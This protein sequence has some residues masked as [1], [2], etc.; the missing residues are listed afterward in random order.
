MSAK[1]RFDLIIS[2][3]GVNL[4]WA[5]YMWTLAPRGRL[6]LVGVSSAPLNVTP[7]AL[8]AGQRSVS[9][10]LVGSPATMAKM[11]D[12]AARHDITP[13]IETYHFDDINAALDR[14]RSGKARYRIVL[15]R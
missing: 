3:V 15:H 7:Y 9:G 4:D 10:S 8:M 13:M 11:L 6:H 5:T 2:T 12:F 1:G 14:L